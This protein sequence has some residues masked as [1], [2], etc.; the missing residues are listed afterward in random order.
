MLYYFSVLN[1]YLDNSKD[2]NN[3]NFTI[4]KLKF[5]CSNFHL[6]FFVNHESSKVLSMNLMIK[7]EDSIQ[8]NCGD[9]FDVIA[10]QTYIFN[11][12]AGQDGGFYTKYRN[13]IMIFSND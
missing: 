6:I 10:N 5:F 11:F 3:I 2:E 7:A 9:N 8:I 12:T 13:L 1:L 4:G